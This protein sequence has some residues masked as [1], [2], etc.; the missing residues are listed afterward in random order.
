M[1][2]V[3][4]PQSIILRGDINCGRGQLGQTSTT[5]TAN[6]VPIFHQPSTNFP[7]FY[8][9]YYID[10]VDNCNFNLAAISSAG[11]NIGYTMC[12]DCTQSSVVGK[13]LTIL[14]FDGS[15]VGK[16][17]KGS[18]IFLTAIA[19]DSTWKAAYAVPEGR[20]NWLLVYTGKYPEVRTLPIQK[21]F[22]YDANFQYGIKSINSYDFTE[23]AN[24]VNVPHPGYTN[25]NKIIFEG[26]EGSRYNLAS[27]TQNIIASVISSRNLTFT[28]TN[29]TICSAI[30][31]DS[32]SFEQTGNSRCLL[33]AGSSI[34]T[35]DQSL[36]TG[37]LSNIAVLAAN[38]STVDANG[39]TVEMSNLAIIGCNGCR[40]SSL[41]TPGFPDGLNSVIS[42]SLDSS[43][44]ETNESQI[45][46]SNNSVI[47]FSA[48]CCI[49]SSLTG[50]LGVDNLCSLAATREVNIANNVLSQALSTDTTNLVGN[51]SLTF[52]SVTGYANTKAGI[53]VVS[54][55]GIPSITSAGD[56]RYCL[57]GGFNGVTWSIDS[58][59][60][61]HYGSGY[62]NTQALP[63]FAEMF[64]NKD[65]KPIPYGRL[66]QLVD[67]K[68]RL[69]N[70]GEQGYMIS[71]PYETSAFV[72]G[73][74]YFY[75]HKKY[76]TDEF[77]IP[78]KKE[79]TVDEYKSMLLN[80]GATEEYIKK[81]ELPDTIIDYE[82]NPDYDPKIVYS[83]RST[84]PEWSTCERT[85][86][87]VVEQDGSL[88]VGDYVVSAG[89]GIA[90][91]NP[92]PTNITVL[93]VINSGYAK[94]DISNCVLPTYIE[95]D[96]EV[97]PVNVPTTD[98]G[99]R[100]S[101][102]TIE[103]ANRK[104]VKLEFE[105][106]E[107]AVVRIENELTAKKTTF[108]DG[109]HTWKG[110]LDKGTY[111]IFIQSNNKGGRLYVKV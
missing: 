56:I 55:H 27:I 83:P 50:G 9:N 39:N 13:A 65:A 93:E 16:V 36:G 33:I 86:I 35:I 101:G 49:D 82:R 63:G 45:S 37:L 104:R 88:Q 66:L 38:G 15:E 47:S 71:R 58:K 108:I 62:N 84:R 43:I 48:N 3:P 110:V 72:G 103:V 10:I 30:A 20:D 18:K 75:W 102:D 95:V 26:S 54:S 23:P 91:S 89:S 4:S 61:I 7:E 53:T 31:T 60:G 19:T 68:V 12:I 100:I 44:S 22:Y 98:I 106:E 73:N 57:V 32:C 77:N 97:S 28:P 90:T 67:G 5:V 64:E 87:T 79:Y 6:L 78:K 52:N 76:V 46:S 34:C 105:L 70:K 96:F 109:I 8:H 69:S 74:P 42:S 11:V 81:L 25:L 92:R 17:F 107:S 14:A 21:E 80:E 40:F 85:G 99:I 29:Y 41:G 59:T 24:L 111:K 1:S 51:G 94:V 2:T